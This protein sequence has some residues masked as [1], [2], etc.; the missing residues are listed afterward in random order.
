MGKGDN[1]NI[2]SSAAILRRPPVVLILGLCLIGG[3]VSLL[4]RLV[5]GP[6]NQP[7]RVVL[8]HEGGSEAAPAFSRDGRR[9]AYSVREAGKDRPYHIHVRTLAGGAVT[10]LT[11][12]PASDLGP[13]WS[14]DGANIAFLRVDQDRARYTVVS[15]GGGEPRQ[16]ADLPVP[17]PP[18]GPQPAVCWTR[19]GQSL[20][21]VQW[22]KGQPPSIGEV[23][24][25]GGA[26]RRVTQPPADSHG[27]GSPA[28]SPDGATLAFVRQ[29]AA[30]AAH[31]DFGGGSGSGSD[32]YLCDLS[33]NNL[34]RLTF[35][36]AS[37]SGIAWSADGRDV[38]YAANRG[39]GDRLWR[40]DASGGSPRNVQA[41]GKS[42]AFPA[43]APAG[44]RLAYTETPALDAI[45]RIDLNAPDPAATGRLLIRSDG[46]EQS[47]SWSPDGTK[48]ANIS[49]HTG[50]DEIWVGDAEGRN[51]VAITHLRAWRLGW[52]RWS[53]DGRALL[54]LVRGNGTME[55]DRVTSD[56]HSAAARVQLPED[57]QQVAWS[58][59]GSW[60]YFQSMA[61]IWK[62]RADGQQRQK[63]TNNWGDSEP[64]ESPDGKYVYFRRER[65]IWRIPAGG[66]TEEEVVAPDRDARWNTF[67]VAA[68][69][70]Y[71]L[72]LDRE[73][74]TVALRFYDLQSKKS[75]E[76]ARLPVTDP[77][78][79]ST[80][81]VSPDGRHLLYAAVDHAQTTL[82]LTENF[83]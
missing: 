41:G 2:M 53:P 63:V 27:D 42:Q 78:S 3:G 38:I 9:L 77:S 66:G 55:V 62:A 73:E 51:R 68:A 29:S 7:K 1:T 72:E 80:F 24:A 47:P 6:S 71:L 44:H 57:S 23:P 79:V 58:H 81:S 20:Y 11:D 33:G 5:T 17:D 13:A 18:P 35:E 22:A 30:R 36:N 59:D 61:Q 82:V 26:V 14:R 64:K 10:Q 16:V 8:P 25:A 46:R 49:T 37:V 76:L 15:S 21:I 43:V 45:W 39:G 32:V 12:G 69:G 70:L 48:I 19:D 65:S 83:R 60:I 56:G 67:Q 4:S 52:P 54:F 28:V 34:R 74:R 75:R 50:G 31:G 40:I